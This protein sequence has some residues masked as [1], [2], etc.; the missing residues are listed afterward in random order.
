M[1]CLFYGKFWRTVHLDLPGTATTAESV[2]EWWRRVRVGCRLLT[3]LDG[4]FLLR[5][6]RAYRGCLRMFSTGLSPLLCLSVGAARK[7]LAERYPFGCRPRRKVNGLHRGAIHWRCITADNSKMIEF[8]TS[9]RVPPRIT[10]TLKRAGLTL[11]KDPGICRSS[12]GR[13]GGKDL[14]AR[15]PC[16]KNRN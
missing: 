1:D 4:V 2:V 8:L 6:R 12:T 3:F 16:S 14:Q 5:K 13:Q 11:G 15:L 10:W 9:R 7:A